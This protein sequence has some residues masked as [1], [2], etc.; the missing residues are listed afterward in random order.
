M[1]EIEDSMEGCPNPEIW[2]NK[3]KENPLRVPE[4]YFDQ[5]LEVTSFSAKFS[6]Q[7]EDEAAWKVPTG[8]FEN[9]QDRIQSQI[10]LESRSSASS[11]RENGGF[12]VPDGYFENLNDRIRERVAPAVPSTVRSVPVRKFPIRTWARYAAAASVLIVSGLFI[13]NWD[14]NFNREI[15]L[16]KI[17]DQEI[18]NYLSTFSS[19]SDWI[20]LSE[21][22]AESSSTGTISDLSDDEINWF[23]ENS[24]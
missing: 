21:V 6:V 10:A 7:K 14:S 23:L 16:E 22:T 13:Q 9:L 18:I 12:Q 24:L 3:L 5:L 2:K 8:Y 15:E 19:T 1:K 11:D 17:S 20:N 4:G